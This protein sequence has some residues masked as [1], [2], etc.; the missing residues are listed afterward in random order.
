[1]SAPRWRI[2]KGFEVFVEEG[3]SKPMAE[4]LAAKGH[5]IVWKKKHEFGGAQLVCAMDGG[6]M[7]AS[8]HRKDGH[9]AAF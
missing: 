1:M 5:T 9:S 2:T 7:G 3:F 4:A 6:Y 8:D